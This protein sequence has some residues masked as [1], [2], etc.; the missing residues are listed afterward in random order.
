MWYC[1]EA[2]WNKTS[3]F[4]KTRKKAI[5]GTCSL[6]FVAIRMFL[7]K[8]T[9]SIYIYLFIYLQDRWAKTLELVI[10]AVWCQLKGNIWL[11]NCQSKKIVFK[12]EK[13]WKKQRNLGSS[14]RLSIFK[15]YDLGQI[16][17][18]SWA[19]SPHLKCRTVWGW[20]RWWSHP[21]LWS[22]KVHK[23]SNDILLS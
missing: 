15:L 17:W 2:K 23:Y 8:A 5:N 20:S 22:S 1:L 10:S 14:P 11:Q 3:F 4:S 16:N 12:G 13:E 21:A 19:S 18:F 6:M 7:S 9:Q